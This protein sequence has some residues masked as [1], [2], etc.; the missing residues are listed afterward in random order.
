MLYVLKGAISE[1]NYQVFGI[2]DNLT[3]LKQAAEDI[4]GQDFAVAEQAQTDY[5][6]SGLVYCPLALNR[7]ATVEASHKITW[8]KDAVATTLP[9]SK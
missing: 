4:I 7:T 5:G 9:V 2:Y 6:F 3:D 1:Y 8:D